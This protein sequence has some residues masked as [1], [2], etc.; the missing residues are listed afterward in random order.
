MKIAISLSVLLLTLSMVHGQDLSTSFGLKA[1]FNISTLKVEDGTD[2]NDKVG[3]HVGA[4]AHIHVS[5]HF[6]VQPELVYSEQGGKYNGAT[7]SVNYLTLPVLAQYMAGGG[8]RLETGPQL[9][10]LTAAKNKN[11]NVEVDVKDDL[12]T[13]DLSWAFGASYLSSVG[14]GVDARY[15]L[16]LTN[17]NDANTP[18]VRNRVFQAGLFYQFMAHYAHKGR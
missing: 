1:G 10:F 18:I 7:L 9:G 8:F 3:F 16:G 4:L 2:Y 6:A 17:I 15:N 5:P 11:G 14:L 13:V 12:K